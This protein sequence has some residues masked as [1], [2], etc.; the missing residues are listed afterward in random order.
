MI[1]IKITRDELHTVQENFFPFMEISIRYINGTDQH[2]II[3]KLFRCLYGQII[4]K[5]ERKIL[6]TNSNNLKLKL[7]DAEAIALQFMLM[8]MPI[9]Q[10]KVWMIRVRQKITD[11]IHKQITTGT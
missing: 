1:S 11:Q 4:E 10:E 5:V 9:D 3:S 8:G 6:L 7:N 2:T